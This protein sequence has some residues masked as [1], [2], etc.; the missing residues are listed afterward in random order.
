[1]ILRKLL[2]RL[3]RLID[4]LRERYVPRLVVRSRPLAQHPLHVGGIGQRIDHF[5]PH[6]AFAVGE[7]QL[8]RIPLQV[9]RID[10]PGR[11]DVL[12]DMSPDRPEQTF[13][14]K[15]VGRTHAIGDKRLDGRLEL[16]V[17]DHFGLQV[18]LVEQTFVKQYAGSQADPF[19]PPFRVQVNL[20]GRRRHI[21]GCL[22]I[23]VGI[24]DHPFARL[25][26]TQHGVAYLL[27]RRHAEAHRRSHVQVDSL[28]PVVRLGPLDRA[29]HVDQRQAAR[30]FHRQQLLH[31]QSRER[32]RGGRIDYPLRKIDPQHG[33][34]LDGNRLLAEK[35]PDAGQHH[36]E[37]YPDQNIGHHES[38]QAGQKRLNKLVHLFIDCL[39]FEIT[40]Y[41]PDICA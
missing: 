8:G 7:R 32:I 5:R 35:R 41:R 17:P 25:P 29:E 37:K 30:N 16:S 40:A 6:G 10:S 23:I 38:E 21:I 3:L 27:E 36:D 14:L 20:F 24:P 31:S 34:R 13:H 1:M 28:D 22:R 33:A 9:R 18:H 26:E 12:H 11:S 2:D 15:S 39:L 19:D 4:V